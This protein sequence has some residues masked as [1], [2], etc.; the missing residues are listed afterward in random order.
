MKGDHNATYALPKV[1]RRNRPERVIGYISAARYALGNA[2]ADV[3]NPSEIHTHITDLI[4][5][6][7]EIEDEVRAQASQ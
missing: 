4:E 1:A 7:N 5:Q 6:C 2:L 3:T